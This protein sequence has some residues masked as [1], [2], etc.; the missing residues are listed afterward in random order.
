VS[1]ELIALLTALGI[2]SAQTPL[3]RESS[4]V[5][6]ETALGEFNAKARSALETVP[7]YQD[8]LRSI[9]ESDLS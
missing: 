4:E 6:A 8:W 7:P 5:S 9:L 2:E 3:A 1:Q